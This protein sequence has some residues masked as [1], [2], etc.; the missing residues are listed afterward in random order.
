MTNPLRERVLTENGFVAIGEA[1]KSPASNEELK[2]R[3]MK[4]EKKLKDYKQGGDQF[5]RKEFEDMKMKYE[6]LAAQNKLLLEKL[7]M[8]E[9]NAPKTQQTIAALELE[10][11]NQKADNKGLQGE[12][13]KARLEV[14][15][16]TKNTPDDD[17]ATADLEASE[18]VSEKPSAEVEEVQKVNKKKGRR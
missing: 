18:A 14:E 1:E 11:R 12:L 5:K 8:F 7:K 2:A 10:V 15:Q 17:F 13:A 9:Q 3:L 16:L 4:V 6:Q